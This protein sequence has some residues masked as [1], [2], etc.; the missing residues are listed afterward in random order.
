MSSPAVFIATAK[1]RPGSEGDFTKWKG[2]HD[3]LVGKFPGYI[4][5]DIM[6]PDQHS[7]MWTMVLNFNSSAELNAW[8]Q[9]KERAGVMGELLRLVTGGNIGEVMKKESADSAQPATNVTQVILS[10]VKPGMEDVYRAWAA[11]IQQAQSQYP[12]ADFP[13]RSLDYVTAFRHH[14]ASRSMVSRAG[15][16][17]IASGSRGIY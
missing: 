15:T 13:R 2:R 8:Q 1:V 4:S 17:K 7:D 6:P 16:R 12:A 10:Q 5:S 3:A 9:S 11:R 14:G